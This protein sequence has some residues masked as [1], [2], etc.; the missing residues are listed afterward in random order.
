MTSPV[1][2]GRG[3]EVVITDKYFF[4]NWLSLCVRCRESDEPSISEVDR[5]EYEALVIGDARMAL[6]VAGRNFNVG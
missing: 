5:N 3:T 6:F 2:V 1:A 4:W